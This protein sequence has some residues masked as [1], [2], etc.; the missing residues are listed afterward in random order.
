MSNTQHV[1]SIVFG[2]RASYPK[3]RK[4]YG[5]QNLIVYHKNSTVYQEISN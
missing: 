4:H 5:F 3:R 2:V 1:S